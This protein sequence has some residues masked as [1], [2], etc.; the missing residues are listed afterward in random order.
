MK[1]RIALL[2]EMGLP[3]PYTESR[4]LEIVE[5]TLEAPEPGEMRV[6]LAAAGLCHSDLSTIN[7]D[8]PRVMPMAIGHEAAGIVEEVGPGASRFAPGDHVVMVF[9][10]SCGHCVPCAEGRPALCE[11]GAAANGAGTLISGEKRL[12]AEGETINHH[13]G[14]SAF[15]DRVIVSENSCVKI[16]DDIPLDRAALLGC[17]VLT[18]VGAVLNSGALRPGQ[19]VAVIGLGG[20]GLAGLLGA[21]AGGARRVIAVDLAKDKRDFALE[22]GAT[23]AID[24]TEEGAVETVKGWTSGGVDLAVELAGAV[25][26]LKYAYAITRRGGTT[27]TAGLP[28]PEAELSFPPVSL[29]AEERV[30]KGSYVGSCVPVRDIPRYAA[31][32]M[33]G[34]L[35]IEKLMT[36]TIKL[37]D[38]NEGFERLAAGK[39]IRQVIVFD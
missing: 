30:L 39:A 35:P 8:R 3:R 32:M 20:V 14:V 13:L 10:P 16:D 18:G 29:T 31:M 24:P 38:I 27:V 1:T 33:K 11:P 19:D 25:P 4:P 28:H 15:S 37:E 5:A 26:A 7:A 12:S 34:Q 22:L 2:R 21:I 17:A 36:H 9:V 23:H 6:K